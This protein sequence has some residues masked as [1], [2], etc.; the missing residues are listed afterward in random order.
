MDKYGVAY[1]SVN[2]NDER[3]INNMYKFPQVRTCKSRKEAVKVAS[4]MNDYMYGRAVPFENIS[5]RKEVD[6]K[7]ITDYEIK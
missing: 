1:P 6:W 3:T 5:E 7:Y 4:E 2:G